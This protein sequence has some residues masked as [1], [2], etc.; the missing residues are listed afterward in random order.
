MGFEQGLEPKPAR[1]TG[2]HSSLEAMAAFPDF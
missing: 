1:G 2:I